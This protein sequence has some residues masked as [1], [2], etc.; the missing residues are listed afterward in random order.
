MPPP[1]L[2]SLV[3]AGALLTG[4]FWWALL[5][6]PH[7]PDAPPSEPGPFPRASQAEPT[8]PLVFLPGAELSTEPASGLAESVG[9]QEAGVRLAADP[10]TIPGEALLRF[11]DAAAL[12]GFL[13]RLG[14]SPSLQVLA[15][16]DGF[17]ALRVRFADSADLL[18][19]TGDPELI[20]PNFYVTIPEALTSPEPSG[21]PVGFGSSALSY[22]GLAD[23][24]GL[25][26]GVTLALID[27]GVAPH[28]NFEGVSL[29][30]FNLSASPSVENGHGTAVASI[31][32]GGHLGL[33]GVAPAAHLLS[34]QVTDAAGVTDT[35]TL[36]SAIQQ[37]VDAG[38]QVINLSLGTTGN[39]Q[40]LRDAVAYAASQG[41][42]LVAAAGNNG[43]DQALYP[44]ALDGVVGVGAIDARGELAYF[45]NTGETVD[46]VAPG[47][48]VHAAWPQE[49]FLPFS[50]TSSSTPFVSGAIA[51]TLSSHS[52][53]TSSQAAQ[54]VLRYTNDVGPLGPDPLYGAGILDIGRSLVGS[55]PGV[56]DLALNGLYQPDSA[57]FRS[58]LLV[59]NR[60]TE[61]L[62]GAT[63]TVTSSGPPQD[64][65]VPSLAP[66]QTHVLQVLVGP[67]GS[68]QAVARVTSE[69]DVRPENNRL[70]R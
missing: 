24:Q 56:V 47:Y 31:L 29:Q 26:E 41:A 53:L 2:R 6:D 67:E 38:A 1:L 27:S 17:H 45:S 52:G 66:G 33:S 61:P 58:Q 34:Y 44:A 7:P 63:V 54:H 57:N 59:Q 62:L 64:F 60:G 48:Q 13:A 14:N 18:A 50:G 19:A 21:D 11:S 10:M 9:G 28:S 23:H 22:L 43:S 15:R 32:V 70:T 55:T 69:T 36:A 49:R 20:E 5:S 68:F 25:G 39:S 46:L 35:F 51:A 16:L 3:L 40:L 12:E 42:V 37:A 4:F 30:H 8:Q 65:L